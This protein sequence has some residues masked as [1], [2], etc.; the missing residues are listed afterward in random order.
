MPPLKP[1]SKRK[2]SEVALK[3][4]KEEVVQES[5]SDYVSDEVISFVFMVV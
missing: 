2:A 5:E 4:E 3:S 1:K